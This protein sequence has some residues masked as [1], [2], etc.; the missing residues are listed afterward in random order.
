MCN[1][2]RS[3]RLTAAS[4]PV[5]RDVAYGLIR[6]RNPGPMTIRIVRL[7]TARKAGEGA[8]LGTVRRRRAAIRKADFARLN[9]NDVWVPELAPTS[10][11]ANG[12]SRCL[13]LLQ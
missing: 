6:L 7:G 9:F 11:C 8:C 13:L 5:R 1:S 12:F 10:R 3:R 4:L 2:E